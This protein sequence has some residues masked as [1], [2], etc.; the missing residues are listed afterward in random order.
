[1]PKS[2]FDVL[3]NCIKNGEFVNDISIFSNII[4]Y[5]L[6]TMTIEEIR[7]LPDVS[8]GLE[9]TIKKAVDSTNNFEELI[10]LIKSKRYT[11]TRINRILLYA[12]LDINKEYYNGTNKSYIR[13]LGFSEK[14]KILLSKINKQNP[15]LEIITSIKKYLDKNL[16]NTLL[17]LDIKATNIY[18]L[19]YKNNSKANLDFIKKL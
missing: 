10:S 13:V 19:G 4:I 18:T 15:N 2:S 6:R 17:Q 14:G 16:D 9:Y 3:K 1:M 7:N 5:K 12:L 11:R 8:E